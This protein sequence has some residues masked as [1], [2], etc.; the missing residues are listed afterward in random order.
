MATSVI[1]LDI[2]TTR[3]RAVEVQQGRG[4]PTVVRYAEVP[5][6]LGAIRDGEVA[7]PD[8]VVPLLRQLWTQGKFSHRNVIL[9]VGN[10]R[11]LVRSLDLPWMPMAQLRASL[12]FQVQDILPVAVEDALLDYYPTAEYEGPNGRTVHGLLVAATRDTVQANVAAAESAGLQPRMVDLNAFALLR[13]QVGN[14]YRDRTVALVDIGA[15]ITNVVVVE[16]GRPRLVRTLPS[17]AQ[18]ITDAVAAAMS[19]TVAE[20]EGVKRQIG[21][22]YATGQELQVAAEVVNQ[23]AQTLVESIR[24][25]FVYYAS[26]NPGRAAELVVLTGGGSYLNGLG[27][28][29]SS[30][31]RMPVTLGD[32][33]HGMNVAK[34]AQLDQLQ[35]VESTVAVP[36][37]LA[38]GVAA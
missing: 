16:N 7:E 30:A 21:V 28:Y 12:P 2:G 33:L 31:S 3:V 15:R 29:L 14:Q 11:V 13:A 34:S 20:A 17:G 24:N 10:Q 23:V 1:G 4:A 27:Q 6:P 18:N 26:N 25:T 5:V 22:G 36:L 8:D 19:V 9:G 35:G 37:G 32:P 38:L